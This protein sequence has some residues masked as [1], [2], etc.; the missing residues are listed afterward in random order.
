MAMDHKLPGC[1]PSSV[2]ERTR[3][4]E[5][6]LQF[7]GCWRG[8][9]VRSAASGKGVN[10]PQPPT[11]EDMDALAMSVGR[12]VIASALL[13]DE[14]CSGP[15]SRQPKRRRPR[16]I[17]GWRVF[18]TWTMAWRE[19]TPGGPFEAPVYSSS[20]RSRCAC[21]KNTYK[22]CTSRIPTPVQCVFWESYA[23]VVRSR[24]A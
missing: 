20:E 13:E 15:A 12:V 18:R 19:R 21:V 24:R 23:D 22:F 2:S 11:K 10:M 3:W 5:R 8:L 7:G 17:T 16:T 9:G 6:A 4:R 14:R 1:A